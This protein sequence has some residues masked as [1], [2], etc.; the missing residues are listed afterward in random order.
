[1]KYEFIQVDEDTTKLKYKD[2]EFEI[3]RNVKLVSEI[4]ALVMQSR[5]KMIQDFAKQGISIK[6]LTIET[7]KDGK[8][9][10]DNSNRIELEKI[11]KEQV[12]LEYFNQKYQE[13]FGMDMDELFQ[14]IG[15][16]TKEEVEK[17]SEELVKH[18]NGNTP[19]K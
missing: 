3:K 7:K 6:D 15:I 14:D 13:M 11:Y 17:F 5:V 10:Y 12:T 2:K 1:M 8:T 18:I 19:R 9:Y 16:T 4:Q